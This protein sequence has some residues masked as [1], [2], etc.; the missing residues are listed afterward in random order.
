MNHGARLP[1]DYMNMS[2]RKPRKCEKCAVCGKALTEKNKS[3][4]CGIHLNRERSLDY[5][6]QVLK[7]SKEKLR[8]GANSYLG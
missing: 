2:N 3:R 6:H 7:V 8:G 5:Y 1:K 4:L